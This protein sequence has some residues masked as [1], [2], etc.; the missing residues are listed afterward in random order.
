M[1][2]E[3]E[4]ENTSLVQTKNE[5]SKKINHIESELKNLANENEELL[6]INSK[7]E[8]DLIKSSKESII[9]NYVE[10]ISKLTQ[11]NTAIENKLKVIVLENNELI[12]VKNKLEQDLNYLNNDIIKIKEDNFLQQHTK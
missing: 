12:E 10:Q 9:V 5:L 3:L 8:N 11:A 2:N 7:L 4:S 1:N 6:E